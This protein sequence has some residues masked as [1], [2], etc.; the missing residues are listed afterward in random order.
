ML[1]CELVLLEIDL[2]RERGEHPCAEEYRQRFPDAA[3]MLAAISTDM[4]PNLS[5]SE[6]TLP[7]D[8][9]SGYHAEPPSELG[10]RVGNYVIL[11][12]IARGGMGI[13][14]KARQVRPER[15]VALKMIR[16]G[17]FATAAEAQRFQ[18][19]AEAAARLDHPNIVPIIE[20]GHDHGQWFFS[21][22]LIEGGSLAA[23]LAEFVADPVAAARV[24]VPVARAVDHA[25]RQGFVHRDLKPANVL[26]DSH[27][28]PQVTDFGLAKCVS[29]DSSQTQSGTLVGTP[30]YM[31]PEQA[32]GRTQDVTPRTDVY[33]LGA[34]LYELLTSRPPF[35]GETLMDTVV[36]VLE[37]QP[38]PPCQVRRGVPRD[39]E[40]I[41]LKCL[42]KRPE[43]RYT[44]AAEV[45]D[46]LERFLRDEAVEARRGD[47]FHRLRRWV[48]REPELASRLG[49]LGVMFLLTMLNHR[50]DPV[51]PLHPE[52]R[53]HAIL[54]V[55]AAWMAASVVLAALGRRSSFSWPVPRCLDHGGFR[56]ADRRVAGPRCRGDCLHRRLSD[57]DRGGRSLVPRAWSSWPPCWRSPVTPR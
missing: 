31:A 36:Q 39:L 4:D 2:R 42:E 44:S 10:R 19:E 1:L 14:Y 20:V 3:A 12:E 25:H 32:A 51:S 24:L 45:A 40:R 47:T 11:S 21:M 28:A 43:E 54:F 27:G 22:K 34:I 30:S 5:G 16:S 57:H 13:I 6:E 26:L 8:S 48:W 38:E 56:R 46:D 18:F 9:S 50:L 55:L 49:A 23:H 41:C 33:G 17:T 53:Y 35:R 29:D 7:F 52:S 37:R 15:L